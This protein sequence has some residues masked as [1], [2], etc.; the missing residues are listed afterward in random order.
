MGAERAIAWRRA[1]VVLVVAALVTAALYDLLPRLAGAHD[2]WSRVRA[3]DTPWLAAAFAFEVLSFGSYVLLFRAVLGDGWFGWRVSLLITFAGVAM[4]RM[5]AT[6]GAGG[7]ALTAWALRRAGRDARQVA[8]D[9][10]AF[11]V[12]LYSV[13]MAALVVGGL[14]LWLGLL[15]GA[16]PP[17][18]TLPAAAFG[19]GVIAAAL[20][21]ARSGSE[22][23]LAR[24]AAASVRRAIELVRGRDP[25]LLGAIGWWGFDIA[26]LWACLEAFGDAP[27]AA[28]TGTAYFVGMLGNLLP[29]PG[30]V[31]GVD[32][33]MIGALVAFGVA[34]GLAIVGVLA[35]RVFAFWLPTIAGIPACAALVRIARHWERAPATD[36]VSP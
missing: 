2:A 7:I 15:P 13:F 27:P 33:A 5:L 8:V 3:G 34:P 28:V 24:E 19:A 22:R 4:T 30:G 12:T 25:R 11:L 6:G 18:L 10:G 14:G 16:A 23:R 9:L 20:L 31:G 1:I 17:A 36:S 29:L 26:V 35:Y 21:L 32:G